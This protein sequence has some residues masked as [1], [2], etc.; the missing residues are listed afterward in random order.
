MVVDFEFR[1]ISD[2]KELSRLRDF[3]L[4]QNLGYP[5]YGDW[6]DRCIK[7]I[8]MGDKDSILAFSQDVLVG[9]L[10]F[11]SHKALPR[12]LELK[13]LRIH[14]MMIRRDFGHFMLKQVEVEA[15]NSGKYDLIMGDIR[16]EQESIRR[17]C[18]FS[19]YKELQ[20]ISLYDSNHLDVVVVKDLRT[21]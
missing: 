19:G 18:V 8:D 7:E 21:Q 13:N 5:N 9:D 12:T 3:L 11:Q 16:K 2:E 20:T 14:P 17:L 10:I 15:R 4:S 1:G 6:V